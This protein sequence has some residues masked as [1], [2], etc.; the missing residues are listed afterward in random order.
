MANHTILSG[1]SKLSRHQRIELLQQTLNLKNDFYEVMF[2]H[3]HPHHQSLFDDFSENTLTNYYLPFGVAPNFLID[4]QMTVVPMVTEESSVVAA[5]SKAA[6]FWASHGGF[7]TRIEQ[8]KKTGQIHFQWHGSIDALNDALPRIEKALR[9]TAA[10]HVISMEQR[11]GGIDEF[12]ILRVGDADEHLWQ[13][14]VTFS[15]ADAMGANFINST[16][17]AMRPALEELLHSDAILKSD[18][19]AQVIM[20]I[21]SNYTPECVIRCTVSCPIDE[22]ESL[23][24]GF[25]P[26]EFAERF[27]QAVYIASHDVYRA[28]T[29]NKGIMN[30]MDAV[31]IATGNDFRAVE[32]NA[33]AFASRQGKYMGLTTL[34]LSDDQF[35][36]ELTVPL[37]VG[38]VGGLTTL[39]PVA[40][41]A[42]EV[43]GNP[44]ARRL[45]AIV[46]AAGLANNFMAVASLVTHG[47]QQGHMKLHLSNM[48]RNLEASD[49][50]S[51]IIRKHFSGKT[52][53]YF[54]VKEFLAAMRQSTSTQ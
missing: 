24:G 20:C 49:T 9:Q 46:A 5:A 36:Y 26:R 27:R 6:R 42:L 52:V 54:A 11:G 17:E 43:M 53:S 7:T 44:D 51:S 29:H 30:G 41:K 4:G 19:R 37:S 21:L 22:L 33:H 1:F 28:T 23:S 8:M 45:M 3:L 48:I 2:S 34:D 10:P 18:H 25:S 13:L 16:L 47:I 12:Q 40:R 14:L 38:T 39:H 15:T 35:T 31:V 50:E 32:A